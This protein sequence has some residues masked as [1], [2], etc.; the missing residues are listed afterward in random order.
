[1]PTF[2][3]KVDRFQP[4]PEDGH[5]QVVPFLKAARHFPLFFGKSIKMVPV[6]RSSV[7]L[8]GVELG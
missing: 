5:V 7:I 2:F 3:A 6:C 8:L 4:V 1:M